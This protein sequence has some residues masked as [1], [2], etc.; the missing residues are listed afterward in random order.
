LGAQS[1]I[2]NL[3]LTPQG[4]G[5]QAKLVYPSGRGFALQAKLDVSKINNPKQTNKMENI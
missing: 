4:S 1:S 5:Y 3:A 2:D